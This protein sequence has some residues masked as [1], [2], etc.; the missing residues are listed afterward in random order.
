MGASLTKR[1]RC[2]SVVEG[3]ESL[4]NEDGDSTGRT[5]VTSLTVSFWDVDIP[6]EIHTDRKYTVIVTT[7]NPD[8]FDLFQLNG[9]YNI[10]V[11][12]S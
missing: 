4:V 11:E 5:R 7:M 2:H 8:E 9:V 10:T 12:R 3:R 1:L 6:R